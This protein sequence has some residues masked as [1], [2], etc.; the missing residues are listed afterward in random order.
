MNNN[1]QL[2]QNW[3]EFLDTEY[4]AFGLLTLKIQAKRQSQIS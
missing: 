4:I 1:F 2:T 3:F